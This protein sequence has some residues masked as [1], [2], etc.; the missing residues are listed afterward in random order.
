MGLHTHWGRAMAQLE[1]GNI[2]LYNRPLVKNP[3]GSTSTV[4]SITVGMDGR[5]YVLPTVHPEGRIM[6]NDEAVD[7]FKKTGQHLGAFDDPKAADDF[8]EQL[9]KQQEMFYGL[10]GQ[11]PED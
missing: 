1:E 2:D 3:D 7:Y 9:H 10:G 5:H 4:R 6:S 8:A 11:L